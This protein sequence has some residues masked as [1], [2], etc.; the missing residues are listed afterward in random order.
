MTLPWYWSAS[1]NI[2]M[3]AANVFLVPLSYAVLKL[4]GL[5]MSFVTVLSQRVA[6][7]SF[8]WCPCVKPCNP[9]EC[10]SLKQTYSVGELKSHLIW[11]LEDGETCRATAH[12]WLPLCARDCFSS[13]TSS[14]S[15]C[16]GQNAVTGLARIDSPGKVSNHVLHSSWNCWIFCASKVDA[17]QANLNHIPPVTFTCF[18]FC[19]HPNSFPS[20]CGNPV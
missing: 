9:W 2:V 12:S 8:T 7:V 5:P 3:R 13:A 10:A 17:I 19:F 15:F 1:C 20:T 4:S 11:W 18:L 6:S 14:E 16:G